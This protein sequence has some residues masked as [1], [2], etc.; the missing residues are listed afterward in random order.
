[1]SAWVAII[2]GV[3]A[4]FAGQAL[5]WG[6]FEGRVLTRLDAMDGSIIELKLSRTE[7]WKKINE[8]GEK[9]A[10]VEATCEQANKGRFREL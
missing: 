1:M 10:K 5:Y 2:I 3:L 6:R 7:M 4:S 8:H 9:I